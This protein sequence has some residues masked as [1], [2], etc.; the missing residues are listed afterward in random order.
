MS[1]HRVPVHRPVHAGEHHY[2][3]FLL[4]AVLVVA[5]IILVASLAANP[6][7][8]ISTPN[9]IAAEQARL[10]FRRGEWYASQIATEMARLEFRRGEWYAR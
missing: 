6:V 1:V 7:T 2:L 4:A 10:E 3:I 8:T 9:M 5:A